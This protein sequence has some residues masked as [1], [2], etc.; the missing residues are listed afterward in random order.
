MPAPFRLEAD[1]RL[2]HSEINAAYAWAEWPQREGWRLDAVGRSCTWFAARQTDDGALI[3]IARLL[4]DGG[5]HAALW[6][7]IVHPDRQRQGIGRALVELAVERCRDRRLVAL[8]ATPA[9]VPFF[10]ALGF[11]PESHGHTAMYLRPH[12]AEAC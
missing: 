9:S 12:L 2:S 11:V 4:D 5:L 8:V 7:V 1:A 6:D 10:R 3:G